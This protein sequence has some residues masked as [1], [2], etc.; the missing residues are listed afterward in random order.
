VSI[1]PV[2]RASTQPPLWQSFESGGAEAQSV[3]RDCYGAPMRDGSLLRLPLRDY[4]DFA[5]AGFI[6]NQAS[7]AVV[8]ALVRWIAQD[9]AGLNV[10]VVVG[11]PT[12][13]HVIGAGVARALGH[14]NWVA[15]GCTRKIWYDEDLSVPTQSVTAPEHGRR[16]WLDP[17]LLD[18]LSG[19]RALLVDDVVS[20]GSSA[21]AGI[22]LLQRAGVVPA[23]LAVAMIQGEAWRQAWDA[24]I[25]V[26]AAFSTPRFRR[27]QSGWQPDGTPPLRHYR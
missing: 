26:Y 21:R 2:S 15:V 27:A 12:I 14:E 20:S 23:A 5:I 8:D 19:R 13:G 25:P 18:R 7:F 3:W 4:G 9:V 17:R 22:S 10:E 24:R 6:A 16:M 1:T 11:L